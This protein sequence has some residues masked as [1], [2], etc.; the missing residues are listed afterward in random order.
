MVLW[1]GL[2]CGLLLFLCCSRASVDKK[3]GCGLVL[4]P[5]HLLKRNTETIAGFAALSLDGFGLGVQAAN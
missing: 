2:N 5:Q 4:H 3:C 1:G